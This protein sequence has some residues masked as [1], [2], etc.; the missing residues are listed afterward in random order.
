MIRRDLDEPGIIQQFYYALKKAQV[1][2][3]RRA[4]AKTI[5]AAL[6]HGFRATVIEAELR[7]ISSRGSQL[8]AKTEPVLSTVGASSGSVRGRVVND[9]SI[10]SL[11]RPPDESRT[12]VDHSHVT[13]VPSANS[14]ARHRT[15]PLLPKP[16]EFDSQDEPLVQRVLVACA[17]CNKSGKISDGRCDTI[18]LELHRL[19]EKHGCDA[20]ESALITALKKDCR[21]PVPYAAAIMRN[22][23]G[24]ATFLSRVDEESVDPYTD[25]FCEP[26]GELEVWQSGRS[27]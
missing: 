18:R 6:G 19:L 1:K 27:P 9:D 13:A 10:K 23:G 11:S 8:G 12:H 4:L 24:G 17:G 14:K 3:T 20:W 16:V 5:Q 7:L 2:P 21:D 15:L 25:Y 22:G 26:G